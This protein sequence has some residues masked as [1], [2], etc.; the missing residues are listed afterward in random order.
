LKTAKGTRAIFDCTQKKEQESGM[1]IFFHEYVLMLRNISNKPVITGKTNL[2]LKK[3]S[4]IISS[5]SKYA[6]FVRKIRVYL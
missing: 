1:I 2:G 3:N 4:L 5:S 6:R